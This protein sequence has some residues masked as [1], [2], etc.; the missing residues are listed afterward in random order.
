MH[1]K[2]LNMDN[3]EKG[4]TRKR[5]WMSLD[6][7]IKG[8]AGKLFLGLVGFAT[9]CLVPGFAAHPGTAADCAKVAKLVV[10]DTAITSATLIPAGGGLP[11]YCRVQGHVDKEIGFEVRLPTNWNGKFYFQGIPGMAGFIPPPGP[12][13]V[14]GYAVATTDTGHGGGPSDGS[15]A[16]DNPER[17][18]NFGHRAVHVVT[19]AAKQIVQAF[20]EHLPELSYFE[21]CS[22]GGRQALMEAQRYPTD[23]DGII[24]GAPGLDFT[25]FMM[26][27]NWNAQALQIAAIPMSKVSL[28][29]RAVLAECDGRDG[30][31]DGLISDPRRCRFDPKSLQCPAGDAPDCLTPEQVQVVRMIYA[32]PV[33][34]DGERLYPGRHQGHEDGADG[35]PQWI[36]GNGMNPTFGFTTQDQFLRFFIFG[37]NFDSLTFDFDTDPPLVAPTG[38]FLN[39]IDPDLSAFQANDGK[40]ILWQGWADPVLTASRTVEYYEEVVKTLGDDTNQF[41]RLFMAPGVHHCGGGPGPNTFDLLTAL[42]NWVEGGIAPDRIVASHRTG[43]VVDRTRPLCPY[44]Q[45]ARYLG[46]GSIDDA[47]NFVCDDDER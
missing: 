45:E 8:L 17:Q 32:G 1:N 30:L 15:W 23:F 27:F 29:A 35:W 19:V 39:A 4:G 5:F 7:L 46:K 43:E 14:R 22:N 24:A 16:L 6:L 11:E 47:A 25:G 31:K 42:E 20:Y 26:G 44:P 34:T 2:Y 28:I 13:L 3:F 41:F 18:V 33:N 38:E 21:G 12:S 40:L 36:T 37:P 10:E 9:L